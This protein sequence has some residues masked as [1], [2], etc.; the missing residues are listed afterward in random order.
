MDK[1]AFDAL[2][3]AHYRRVLGLCRR[4]LGRAAD[5]EDATQEIF[6]RGFRAFSS[7]RSQDPFG[8]WIGAIASNYC[9][10]VLRKERRLASV[11]KEEAEPPEPVSPT[12]N[13]A[14]LL[15]SAYKADAINQAVEA[16][17]E[18]YRLPVVLAYYADASYEEIAD[19]LGITS[20][21][22]GVLLLRGKKRLRQA[23]DGSAVDLT[24]YDEEN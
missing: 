12:E 22:V 1:V 4:M 19:T 18:Q 10:D 13:G 11:F 8:P 14:A 17:P 24:R 2:Y 7:Y 6:M 15:I 9:I 20:N 5:A 21:H 16:L 23:L 3:Q